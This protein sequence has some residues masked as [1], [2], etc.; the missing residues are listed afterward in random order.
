MPLKDTSQPKIAP[1]ALI[2][3]VSAKASSIPTQPLLL[4]I[5]SEQGYHLP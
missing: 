2:F 4:G 5:I 3:L 1:L